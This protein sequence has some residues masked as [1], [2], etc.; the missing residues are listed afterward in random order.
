[1]ATVTVS[2]PPRRPAPPLPSGQL[3]L[4]APPLI[5]KPQGRGMGQMLMMLPMVGGSAAMALTFGGSSGGPTRWLMMGVMGLSALGM[6]GMGAGGGGG[7]KEMGFARRD[8]LR[9]L[10]QH[11]VRVNRVAQQQ[12]ETLWYLHPDPDEL[13]SLAAGYRLWERRRE[14]ADF[15]VARIGLGP[16]ALATQL[17]PPATRSLEALEPLS[18]LALRRFITA[19]TALADM[20]AAMAVNGFGRVYVRGE[21]D[22]VIGL[23]RAV[24]AQLVTFHA[25]N[26]L[27]I[28]ACVEP[29]RQQHWE[30]LKWLPHALHPTDTDALGGIRLVAASVPGLEAM[31]QDLIV[32]RPRFDAAG[33]GNFAGPQL[34]IVL[35]GGDPA[36][37]DH[38]LAGA[39][40]EGVTIIDL[41]NPPPRALDRATVVLDVADHLTSTTMSGA[42]RLGTPDQLTLVE[43]EMLARQLSPLRLSEDAKQGAPLTATL[44]IADLLGLG[45]PYQF[46]P[47]EHWVVRPN[48]QRLRVAFGRTPDGALVDLDLKESAQDGM[49]PHGLLI[50]ATGSGKS[51]LL[52]TLVLGLAIQHSPSSLNFV[53]VDFKGGATFTRLD[54]LP[55]T[56]AVITN[57][58]DELPLVD[59]MADALQGELQR[60]QELLRAAGNYASLHD[61]ERARKTTGAAIPELPTLLVIC[62]EF[63]ELLSQK[64]DF[65][66]MFVQIAR[67]GRSLGVHLLL[68]SQRLEEGKLRGLDTFLSYRIGLRTFNAVESRVVLGVADAYELPEKPGHG[69]LK[70]GTGPMTRFR[71]AYVSG[72]HRRPELAAVGS[73]Q[74][75]M[76]EL[77]DYSCQYV[78]PELVDEGE[79]EDTEEAVGE[80]VLDI[81]VDRMAG[82]GAPAHQVW[83]PPLNESA[84]LDALLPPLA[85]DPEHGLTVPRQSGLRGTLQAVVG[86]LD[87]PYE[88]RTDP[89]V[90]DLSGGGG[91][92][93][94][95]GGPRSGK[96]NLLRVL[97]A[98]LALTNTPTQA[99]FYCLD[100]GGGTLGMLRGLPHV[101]GVAER[102]DASAVRRTVAEVRQMLA[103][104]EIRFAEHGVDN[105]AAYRKAR[106]EG[107]FADDPHGDVFL[108]VDGW[109]TLRNEFD[110]LEDVVTDL[111]TRGLNYGVHV[112]ATS[113]RWFDLRQTIRD[114]FGTRLE[115]RLGDTGDSFLN[116][117]AASNV[118]PKSP[119]RGINEQGLHLLVALPRIDGSAANDDLADAVTALVDRVVA[120]WPHAQVAPRVRMLPQQVDYAIFPPGKAGHAFAFGIAENDLQPV[121]LWPASDPHFLLFGDTESG[122]TNFLRVIA[123]R[124]VEAYQP[125]QARILLV[126]HRRSMLDAVPAE[127]LIGYGSSF[128]TTTAMITE[129]AQYMEQRL[130]GP[131]VTAEQLRERSWWQGMDLYVLVDD[132][133]LVA[134]STGNPL[135]PLIDY[136]AQARDIGLHVILARRS[137]GA[138]RAMFDPVIQRL[139]EIGTPGLVLAGDREEGALLGSVRPSV[140]PPGRGHLVGRRGDAQLVQLALL[141][142][143]GQS[144]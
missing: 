44:G 68:A 84:P 1:M 36:G 15:G 32:D 107:R 85:A 97:I 72:V 2:R 114:Q 108:V 139:R 87:R 13:W 6:L 45:D 76:V 106:E 129:V 18:A 117:K 137:G 29:A 35:D 132:Y 54:R 116:R 93:A 120:D 133:D 138:G 125:D 47:A 52:R 39:G 49:G 21:H 111:A 41:S 33:Q 78:R 71:A 27:L 136:L 28:A 142:P 121:Y 22:R 77:R 34:V 61:Y 30:W 126:D 23:V 134:G 70:S 67:V 50:G 58:T 96:S 128:A 95:I 127:N 16:Q 3:V 124:I 31:L 82:R 140:Q 79:P 69:Y 12:R 109:L 81:L 51:E 62:D 64:P 66:E 135:A 60:R 110:D 46:D 20:P 37:S 14:D 8:Y 4:E 55:H 80:S 9:Q 94:V 130:P 43:A 89:L 91:H 25:P 119:G 57:L 53:L 99:Q 103:E 19:Y 17:V 143:D 38:L 90:L 123:Q 115:L 88:Q 100:F 5:P 131:E 42:T 118:P 105:I 112:V 26:D 104:R 92:I 40:I 102:R 113:A 122:K 63:S 74:G 48:R 10:A 86:L 65:I 75:T 7:R 141:S 144:R 83:L 98:S 73:P 24:L 101:G 11:R 56:S 59:R